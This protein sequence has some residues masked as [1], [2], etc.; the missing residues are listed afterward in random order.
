MMQTRLTLERE[1]AVLVIGNRS[2]IGEGQ[3]SCAYRIEVGNDVMVA[4][5]TT[6]L[7]HGSHA[8]RFSQRANDVAQWLQGSKDW[9]H[10]PMAPVQIGD[11]AWVGF[12]CI[13]LPGVTIGEGAV[14]GAGSVVTRDVA[15][16]TVVAG[17]PA[18]PIREI[19]PDE[20]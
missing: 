10:V 17:N 2:F 15:P 18:R 20:R 11:K 12:G 6:I 16:W 14:V 1:G 3:I 8:L 19:G 9:Q 13:V 4:W 5:G 7:D